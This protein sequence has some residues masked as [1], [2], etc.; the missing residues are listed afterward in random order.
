MRPPAPAW[1]GEAAAEAER[2]V[3]WLRL[4]A[5][6]LRTEL[7]GRLAAERSRLLADTLEAE[8]RE[9]RALAEALHD[10]ALQNLLSARHDLQEAAEVAPH[11]ALARAEHA[12]T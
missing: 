12:V 4:P 3:A 6:A 2:V 1:S 9:R 7:V 11:E 10:R 5:I 8:Q